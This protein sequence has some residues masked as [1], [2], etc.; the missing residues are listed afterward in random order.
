MQL[1]IGRPP[2]LRAL[3]LPLRRLSMTYRQAHSRQ[4]RQ[5]RLTH[6]DF[7]VFLMGQNDLQAAAAE[8]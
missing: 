3:R 5:V 6:Y 7:G 1:S 2:A 4:I 8:V